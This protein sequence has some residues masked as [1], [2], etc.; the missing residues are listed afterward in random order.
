MR[1]TSKKKIT[2]NRSRIG[3]A[4]TLVEKATFLLW[5]FKILRFCK[6]LRFNEKIKSKILKFS[7]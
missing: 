5:D 6:I 2:R 3:P 4:P 1:G 7:K